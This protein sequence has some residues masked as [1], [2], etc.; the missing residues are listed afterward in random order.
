VA[1]R[2]VFICDRCGQQIPDDQIIRVRAE[3]E[4]VYDGVE[5]YNLEYTADWCVGCAG[6]ALRDLMKRYVDATRDLEGYPVVDWIGDH[7]AK[8][9][10][11]RTLCAFREAGV[12]QSR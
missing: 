2:K 12:G 9:A 10:V 5:S 11:P 8:S 1:Q 3:G 4:R 7:K 6:V